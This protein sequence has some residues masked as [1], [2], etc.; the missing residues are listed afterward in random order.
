MFGS[1][2]THINSYKEISWA[3]GYKVLSNE[4]YWCIY[5]KIIKETIFCFEKG[6]R[7]DKKKEIF[8][9]WK[10]TVK[11]NQQIVL[12]HHLI[13]EKQE[14]FFVQKFVG[15]MKLFDICI[16]CSYFE[17]ISPHNYFN[18][19]EKVLKNIILTKNISLFLNLSY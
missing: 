14:R 9:M 8:K 16:F 12:L 17:V 1:R 11:G 19:W 5:H 15:K 6:N 2:K 13:V 10:Q 3:E 4:N 18:N 7:K